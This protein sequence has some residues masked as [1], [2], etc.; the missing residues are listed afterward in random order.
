MSRSILVAATIATL[1]FVGC[2][3]WDIQTDYDPDVKFDT[4]HTYAVASNTKIPGDILAQ[5]EIVRKRIIG[6][7]EANLDA[8]GFT[9][10]AN[11]ADADI[12]VV[13][14]AGVKEVVNY[15]T[16]G[17]SYGGGWRYGA[18]GAYG[19]QV[20]ENRYQNGTLHIDIIDGKK[21]IIAWKGNATGAVQGARTPE[22][23]QEIINDV[24]GSLL[25]KF[26]P[27]K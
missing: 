11:E 4:Y 23:R 21:K 17:Y 26:P 3:G 20:V 7:I 5:E 15:S 24:V 1:L 13:P 8:K 10:M 12:I 2:G 19:T 16:Y 14:Y 27:T 22:E 9:K 18:P 6:A 25:K